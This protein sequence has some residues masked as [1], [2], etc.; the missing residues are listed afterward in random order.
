VATV[1]LSKIK[2]AGGVGIDYTSMSAWIAARKGNLVARDTIEVAWIYGGGSV[3]DCWLE[4]ADW[5]LDANHYVWIMAAPGEGHGGKFRTDKAYVNGLTDNPF[6]VHVPWVRIGPGI[7][8][9]ALVDLPGIVG[10]PHCVL[11]N[12]IPTGGVVVVDGVIGRSS[13]GNCFRA[14]YGDPVTPRVFM[15]CVALRETNPCVGFRA[16]NCTVKVVNCTSVVGD[17]TMFADNDGGAFGEPAADGHLISINNYCGSGVAYGASGGGSFVTKGAKDATSSSEALDPTLRG[18]L[19]VNEF[20]DPFGV[21]PDFH[22]KPTS[23][24]KEHGE[25]A[26]SHGVYHDFEGELRAS[27]FDVG[28]DEIY[29]FALGAPGWTVP[30][31]GK[32]W[33][34]P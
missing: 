20:V 21:V 8:V 18:I 26:F 3:G 19:A 33:S 16:T 4:A 14:E 17:T 23:V 32:I 30:E 27:P 29:K 28:A 34:V 1:V 22:L 9:D 11:V 15:N 5:T 7:C 24:L 25:D 6:W 2:A 12:K 10:G 13:N 31:G